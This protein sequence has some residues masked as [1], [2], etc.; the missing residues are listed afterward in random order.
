MDIL[1]IKCL[2]DEHMYVENLFKKYNYKTYQKK[3]LNSKDVLYFSDP[4][5]TPD[6][7]HLNYSD[8]KLN[9]NRYPFWKAGLNRKMT[10]Q[11]YENNLPW[12]KVYLKMFKKFYDILYKYD[13]KIF[14]IFGNLLFIV[15]DNSLLKKSGNDDIDIG[16]KIEDVEKFIKFCIPDLKKEFTMLI[17]T[18]KNRPFVKMWEYKINAFAFDIFILSHD[19]FND[20]DIKYINNFKVYIPKTYDAFLRKI[21]DNYMKPGEVHANLNNDNKLLKS[22]GSAIIKG[23]KKEKK[24]KKKKN[25]K[26]KKKKKKQIKNK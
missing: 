18:Y 1:N 5:D 14:P 8:K 15:R 13:V 6:V 23:D 2:D 7:Y 9:E 24:R 21:Y 16:I 22:F 3:I 10:L 19:I 12:D 20:F 17:S 26:K 11:Q 4:N 25:K